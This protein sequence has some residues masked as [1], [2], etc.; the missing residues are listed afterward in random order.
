MLAKGREKAGVSTAM[1]MKMEI[2][3]IISRRSKQL[4]SH[5]QMSQHSQHK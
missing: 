2:E 3:N 1:K 5:R 4:L